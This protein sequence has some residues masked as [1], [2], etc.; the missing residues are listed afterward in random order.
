MHYFP[1]S[2]RVVLS[3]LT[4]SVV[5]LRKGCYL[6]ITLAV[7]SNI[8]EC[9]IHCQG[10]RCYQCNLR[11]QYSSLCSLNAVR[12]CFNNTPGSLILSLIPLNE[13]ST[14]PTNQTY[15]HCQHN[16]HFYFHRHLQWLPLQLQGRMSLVHSLVRSHCSLIRLLLPARCAHSFIHSLTPE[17]VGKWMIQCLKT[18]WFCPIVRGRSHGASQTAVRPSV[19]VSPPFMNWN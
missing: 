10:H 16:G 2:T 18:T 9:T 12:R 15:C 19:L 14:V 6:I 7:V 11:V 13:K 5:A 4:I 1:T 3:A 8:H 17:L